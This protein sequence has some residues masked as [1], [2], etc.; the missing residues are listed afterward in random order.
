VT[1]LL[2]AGIFYA[3]YQLLAPG[4]IPALLCFA[5]FFSNGFVG[6]FNLLPGLP[7][8]GGQIL[9]SAV[10]AAT[11]WRTRGTVAAGWVGRVVAVGVVAWAL[12]WPLIQG[13]AVNLTTALWM[14]LIAAFLW[15][16][17]GQAI[18]MAARRERIGRFDARTLAIQTTSLP[19]DATISQARLIGAETS[20]SGAAPPMIAVIDN[21]GQPVGWVNPTAVVDVPAALADRTPITAA[22]V[23][24]ATGS[25]V[26]V[27]LSGLP[28]LTHIDATSSG[29]RIVPVI[30]DDGGLTG[31]IDI[32]ELAVALAAER[33]GSTRTKPARTK[34]GVRA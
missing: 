26:P 15:Q 33:T 22:L 6:L 24:F 12:F 18:A 28:L 29:A 16:G 13:Y 7:L 31:V 5:A 32:R 2:L 9:E 27:G 17:A 14:F 1:N 3:G 20:Q 4:S 19:L 34:K 8:D 30:D 21:A 25:G 23:P 11:G 10:W